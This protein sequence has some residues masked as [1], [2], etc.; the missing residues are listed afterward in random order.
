VAVIVRTPV[1]TSNAHWF[2]TFV[3]AVILWM[4][5]TGFGVWYFDMR[6]SQT[7]ATSTTVTTPPGQGALAVSQAG[8][9]TLA[10]LGRAIFW[11]GPRDGTT[12]ELTQRPDGRVYL[13]YLPAGTPVGSPQIFLT[14]ASYPVANAY[15]VTRGV[16]TQGDAVPVR[17]PDGGVAFYHKGLPT[18]IYLAYPGT[19]YQVEVF[20]PSPEQARKL[21]SS[22]AVKEIQSASGGTTVPKTAAVAVT[23]GQ[24]AKLAARLGRPLYWAG[25]QRG[26]TYELTQTPDGRV[27]VRYLPAGVKVGSEEPYLTIGTYPVA[28][29]YATTKSASKQKGS[30]AIEVPGGVAFYSKSR[31]TSVYVAF[32]G[33]NEQIEVYDPSAALVHRTVAQHLIRPVT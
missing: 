17:V 6:P 7:Q 22:G 2:R 20:D 13:R 24:L 33:V 8:L 26:A 23:P 29:A 9:S 32:Q 11:A 5:L 30:V 19:D 10:S 27:Y 1:T 25:G 15:A 14:I 16:S 21:V 18:N 4:A 12:Y 28:N 31:P 3:G